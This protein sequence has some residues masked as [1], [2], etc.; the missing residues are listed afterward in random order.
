MARARPQDGAAFINDCTMERHPAI[1]EPALR[2][3]KR[4]QIVQ[5]ERR[6]FYICNAPYIRP[7]DPVELIF[8]PDGKNFYGHRKPQKAEA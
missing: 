1:G 2:T 7:A 5:I 3:L 6:G 4:S 8:V